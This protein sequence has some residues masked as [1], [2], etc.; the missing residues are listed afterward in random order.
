[1]ENQIYLEIVDRLPFADGH[2]FGK[3]GSY[4]KL[5][6]W[7]SFAVDP[8]DR[9]QQSVVDIE[10]APVNEE[11]LVELSAEFLM[12]LPV[13]TNKGNKR[14][15][16]DWGNRGNMRALQFFNDA[17]HSNNPT[18]ASHAGNGYLMR[19][20]YSFLWGAW[21]GDVLPGDGRLTM[22]LPVA[23]EK[24]RPI[25]GTVQQEF[26]P[27]SP[28]ACFALSGRAATRSHPTVSRDTT[29]ARLTKRR[30]AEG[31]RIIIPS[32]EWE[33]AQVISGAGMSGETTR[34][35]SETAILP[36][37]EFIYLHS[38]FQ[39]GW[40]YELVYQAKDPLIMGLGHVAV[41]ELVSFLKYSKKDFDG[42]DNPVDVELAYGWGRSQTGRCIRDYIYRGFNCD[43]KGRKVF[44]GLLPHVSGA[45]RMWLNHRFANAVS[46]AGQQYEDHYIYADRFPFSYAE[47]RDHLTG[48]KDAILKRPETDP[49]VMHSQTA[50]EYWQRRGSLVHTDTKGN[51]LQQ[52]ET[53]RI[54]LWASSQHS[55]SPID[56]PPD[57]GICTNYSNIVTTSMIFRAM[58]D[59]MDGWASIGSQPPKSQIP[60]RKD[61]TLVTYEEWRGQF[62]E[63]PGTLL[64]TEPASL[65][66]LDYG[67][68]EDKGILSFPP[69]VV[70]N[71]GYTILVPSSDKD[72]NDAPGIRAPMVQAPMGTYVGWNIRAQGYGYGANYE[73]NGSYIPFPDS[74][75]ER[76]FT[77]DPRPSVLER[78]AN[79]DEYIAAIKIACE[80]LVA[81]GYMI[82]EDIPRALMTASNWGRP[83]H[84]TNL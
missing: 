19:R 53:V 55:S 33:Y 26:I 20:G 56:G 23:T 82:E 64:P 18:K 12:L 58:L 62:P 14:L 10:K 51:D 69:S 48:R 83:R 2:E 37:D 75:E 80:R 28:T 73:F 71:D 24:G 16:F 32:D 46:M 60:T 81:E 7:A 36:S 9:A 39:P 11:G 72:G 61:G 68:D 40:I 79:A 25:T 50:T 66:L 54:Y 59:A 30:Y 34:G 17:P 70:D 29:K 42:N 67:P 43:S 74:P 44:D 84:I 31:E 5:T 21:Q 13:D 35:S 15:F 8:K 65:K 3:T 22:K 38:G 52:P 78:Y 76:I 47:C 4:E 41:R 49:F 77:R 45:G 57:K 6:G 63:I 27:G 1:M